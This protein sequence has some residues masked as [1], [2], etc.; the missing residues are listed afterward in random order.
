MVQR[1]KGAE[2]EFKDLEEVARL[3]ETVDASTS[4]AQLSLLAKE[5]HR[6]AVE[7]LKSFAGSLLAG[8]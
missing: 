2:D 3:T 5:I 8:K 1:R 7:M 6:R 4:T